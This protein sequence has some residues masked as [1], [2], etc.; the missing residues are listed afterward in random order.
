MFVASKVFEIAVVFVSSIFLRT[1]LPFRAI[2]EHAR[3]AHPR[4]L[5]TLDGS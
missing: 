3:A 5:A 4:G 2:E 1:V